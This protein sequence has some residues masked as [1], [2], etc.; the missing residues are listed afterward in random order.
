MITVIFRPMAGEAGLPWFVLKPGTGSGS[1]SA[2][3]GAA[4]LAAGLL[5]LAPGA[6]VSANNAI[7]AASTTGPAAI[8]RAEAVRLMDLRAP[9]I[10]RIY[11]ERQ[12]KDLLDQAARRA[13]MEEVQVQRV[14]QRPTAPQVW[15]GIA[16]PVWALLHPLQAWRILTPVPPEQTV[17]LA[18]QKPD[19]TAGFLVPAALPHY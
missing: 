17:G 2:G 9:D 16:A 1:K 3:F 19:A 4:I 10:S 13:A 6:P 15:N 18:Y 14:Y 11:T 12:I 5:S 8:R 7:E